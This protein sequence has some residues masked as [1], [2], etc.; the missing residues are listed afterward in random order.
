MPGVGQGRAPAPWPRVLVGQHEAL[1][2]TGL[3]TGLQRE[4]RWR[5]CGRRRGLHARPR[6]QVCGMELCLPALA[7]EYVSTVNSK[8]WGHLSHPS[9]GPTARELKA[10]LHVQFWAATAQEPGVSGNWGWEAV[11][12]GPVLAG[13]REPGPALVGHCLPIPGWAGL[14]GP[15]SAAVQPRASL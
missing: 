12:Q 6:D 1:K 14:V 9:P 11:P 10:W 3:P 15:P 4:G 13:R 2:A 7:C 5:E 8:C